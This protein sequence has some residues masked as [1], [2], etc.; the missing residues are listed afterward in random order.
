MILNRHHIISTLLLAA[1]LTALSAGAQDTTSVASPGGRYIT[2]VKPSTNTTLSPPKGTDEKVIQQFL[3]GDSTAAL[4]EAKRD[5]IKR[6]YTRYPRITDITLGLNFIDAVLVAMGQ[7]YGSIDVNATL[8]M[9]NRLQPVVELGVGWARSTPEDRNFTYRGKLSPF[10]RLGVNYNFMFKSE[11]AYQALLGARVGASTFTYDITDI[12][13]RN[14]YWGETT[15]FDITGERSNAVWA[16]LLA[17]M[18]VH[19]WRQ[20]SLGWQLK[21]RSVLHYKA[22]ANSHPWFIPGFGPRK[23]RIG[24]GFNVYYTL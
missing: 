12:S 10:A 18:R 21:W 3:F 20:W 23:Q 7:D 17:G 1:L 19:I 24:F 15:T 5:S 13:Y 22:N 2:P 16:E 11:P 8:N 14:N 6:A 9:W 4:E